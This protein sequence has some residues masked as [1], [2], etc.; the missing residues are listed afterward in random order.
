MGGQPAPLPS[1]VSC[2]RSGRGQSNMD[3]LSNEAAAKLTKFPLLGHV[4][5]IPG[6]RELIPHQTY[7]LAYEADRE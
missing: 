3:R 6:A 5:K 2:W 1:P 4:G 7:P